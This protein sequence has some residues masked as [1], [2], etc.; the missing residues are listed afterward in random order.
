MKIEE[1][2][3]DGVQIIHPN[4]YYDYR[5]SF[6][7][8]FNE[9]NTAYRFVQDNISISHKNV[10]RGLH[11]QMRRFAQ[12]KLVTVLKGSAIDVIV[13]I[14]SESKT[15]G[16]HITVKL[17]GDKKTQ[18]M[19]PRGYAHGFISL[20]D[21]TIFSYKCDNFYYPASEKGIIYNDSDLGID[22]GIENEDDLVIS[23]KDLILPKFKDITF[24]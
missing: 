1:T 17:S 4:I 21:D 10:L 2:K 13:D 16:E 7:E 23:P 15:F 9:Q 12:A 5:G 8:M 22:W 20:E 11:Y 3:L 18:V 19:I 6:L 14:D 24:F